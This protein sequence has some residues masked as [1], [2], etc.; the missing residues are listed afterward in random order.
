MTSWAYFDTS[1]LVKRYI[2]E[3]GSSEARRL[4]KSHRLLTSMIALT[5]AISA[6]SRRCTLGELERHHFIEILRKLKADSAY[7]EFVEISLLLLKEVNDVIINTE[8]RILDVLHLASILMF[9]SVSG[10][11]LPLR[12]SDK[13][14]REAAVKL[15]IE[16]VWVG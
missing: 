16:T 1:V 10:L 4:L 13:K 6:L 15:D 9:Q 2:K 7:W 3:D 11:H 8:L 14:Q 5:E 12:T